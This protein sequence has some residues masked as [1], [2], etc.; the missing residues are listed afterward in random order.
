L[1]PENVILNNDHIP[2]LIG[3]G[4]PHQAKPQ[5]INE[6]LSVLD[7]T[8][9]EQRKG[10]PINSKSNIY[11]LGVILYELLA[12]HRPEIPISSWHIFEITSLPKEV[13]LQDVRPGLA[14]ATYELVNTCLWRHEW[15]RYE[16]IDEFITAIDEAIT[17]ETSPL[18]LAGTAR[19]PQ[20]LYIAVPLGLTLIVLAGFVLSRGNSG[21]DADM[22]LPETA[23]AT[24]TPSLQPTQTTSPTTEPADSDAVS[25]PIESSPT[26]EPQILLLAPE[27]GTEIAGDETVFFDWAYPQPLASDQQFTVQIITEDGAQTLGTVTAPLSGQQYRLT[28][29]LTDWDLNAG[30]H[31]WSVAL[32]NNSASEEL[33]RSKQHSFLIQAET[34]TASLTLTPTS[35]LEVTPTV[36]TPTP[37]ATCAPTPPSSWVVYTIQENDY[38]FNL[39]LATGTTVERLQEVNCL[40]ATGLGVGQRIWLPVLPPTATPTIAPTPVPTEASSG[41][42]GSGSSPSKPEK[43]PPPLPN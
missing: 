2:V 3:L 26:T 19:F 5:Q 7:Y 1:R 29:T 33:L 22:P 39:A 6:Q 35:T 30:A 14:A 12:G 18:R 8:P 36:T 37:T 41:S 38:L 23:V 9:P 34:P 4:L 21:S 40:V 16:T 42:N 28:V 31:Q 17:A 15:Y 10:K 25:V 43:T 20:W 11:S 24:S 32:G 13:P 27:S